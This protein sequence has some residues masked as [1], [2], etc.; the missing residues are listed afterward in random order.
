MLL[1]SYNISIICSLSPS[2]NHGSQSTSIKNPHTYLKFRTSHMQN[3][4]YL[5]TIGIINPETTPH[6]NPSPETIAHLLSTVNFLKSRGFSEPDFPRLAFLCPMLF[7]ATFDPAQ[8]EPVFEFLYSDVGASLEES[9][10]LVL[11]CPGLLESNVEFCLVPTLVYL[12]SLGLEKLNLPTTLNAHLLNTRV[13]KLE[14]KVMFLQSVGFSYE[15]SARVCARLPA[16]FGYSI[17]HNLRPKLEFLVRE[18]ERSIEEVKDFPQYFGFSLSRRI[19]PRHFH[20]KDRNVKIKLN[21]MLLWSD[22]RFYAKY[23]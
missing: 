15:E 13:E 14:E 6:K 7:S 9:C 16:I 4:R 12:K 3:L 5:K 23:K 2:P 10:S 22:N 20:L 1:H 8:V 11:R 18:M 17:E 19:A 21:R